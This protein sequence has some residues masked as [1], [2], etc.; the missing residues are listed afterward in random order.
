M[1]KTQYENVFSTVE[2]LFL[3][4]GRYSTT[5]KYEKKNQNIPKQERKHKKSRQYC[6]IGISFIL[7]ASMLYDTTD[8]RIIDY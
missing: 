3:Y 6:E 5:V 8:N 2:I 4:N 7:Y 1:R